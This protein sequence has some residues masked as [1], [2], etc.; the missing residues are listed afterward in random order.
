MS[1]HLVIASAVLAASMATLVPSAQ[2]GKHGKH[3]GFHIG[4]GHHH[5]H[6]RQHRRH[7][8]VTPV[9]TETYRVKPKPVIKE[10]I[11]V[12]AYAD[13]MGRVYDLASKVWFNGQNSCWSGQLPWTFKAGSWFYGSYRWTET[14]GTWRTNAPEAPLPVACETVPA[15]AG[16]VAP[17]VGQ[18]GG[19]KELAGTQ[20]EAG[21]PRVAP[22]PAMP[23]VKTAEKAPA[24][25]PAKFVLP[26]DGNA[27]RA[28]ECKKY[29]P[30]VGEM[31]P[32]PCNL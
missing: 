15:F 4:G 7:I 5:H 6:H 8:I 17:T 22:K 26:P 9:Y 10:K 3:G 21:E 20:G 19:Q 24:E 28:S 16:K 29:F 27:S 25:E 31:L 18:A 13:G 11:V 32:V 1:K 30:S 12:V 14:A 2:A 23:P